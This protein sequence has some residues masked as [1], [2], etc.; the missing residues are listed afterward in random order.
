MPRHEISVI[1]PALDEEPTIGKVID[2]IPRKAIMDRGYDVDI[3]VV[4]G[5]STDNT[6]QIALEKGARLILQ[7]GR[8]KGLGVKAA[9]EAS[10]GVFVFMMDSDDTYP[11]ER[12]PDMLSLLESGEYDVVLGSRISGDIMPGA[13]SRLNFFGNKVL[14][15]TANVLFPN[16]H[17]LTDL[18]T[19]MWGFRGD[20]VRNLDLEARHFDIEAEM[21]A[22][23]VK[24]GCD[25][26]EVPIEYRR[27]T[28]PSKLNS[29]KHGFSIAR[30]LLM[31][32]WK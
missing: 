15:G 29:V 27:R 17:K 20:V 21:Y 16:G 10:R 4:D 25:I 28:T 5:H 26:G 1:L 8:G 3:M 2:R 22:K 19:G 11:A 18:C 12:I 30:R 14:T 24:M 13:M 9:F 31:E 6:Q 23:C 7:Q 32:K